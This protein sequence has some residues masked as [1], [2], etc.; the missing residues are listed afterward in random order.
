MSVGKEG[1][2]GRDERKGVSAFQSFLNAYPSTLGMLSGLCL[3]VVYQQ[4]AQFRFLYFSRTVF[5]VT[6]LFSFVIP[7]RIG[8][9]DHGFVERE[10]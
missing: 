8:K 9:V 10:I 7:L 4:S 2:E 3:D 5:V 1:G 6:S